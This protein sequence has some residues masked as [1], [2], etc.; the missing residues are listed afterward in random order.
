[1]PGTITPAQTHT[2][3]KPQV[4]IEISEFNH[5]TSD[6]FSA[7]L[8]LASRK[9]PQLIELSPMK[10]CQASISYYTNGFPPSA[11]EVAV[12]QPHS[13]APS[14]LKIPVG[15]RV[16]ADSLKDSTIVRIGEA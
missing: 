13:S 8:I 14:R 16:R 5:K 6:P 11:T 4:T 3:K 10:R 1:M 15:H 12:A 7:S 9:T 2:E